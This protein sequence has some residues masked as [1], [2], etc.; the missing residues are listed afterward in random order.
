MLANSVTMNRVLFCL[1]GLI[2]LSC[3]VWLFSTF[4]ELDGHNISTD[5]FEKRNDNTAVA[6][7]LSDDKPSAAIAAKH[8]RHGFDQIEDDVN[9]I[10]PSSS[11]QCSMRCDSTL[12]MLD[13]NIELNDEEFRNLAA[14]TREIATYL[15]NNKDQR[16]YFMQM[17]LTTTDGD[18]RAYL[19][20]VFKHLPEEQKVKVAESFVDSDNWRVRA[21]G[22]TLI[23]DNGV[24]NLA[25]ASSLMD[26]FS[27]EESSYIKERILAYIQNSPTLRGDNEM[28]QQLDSAIY[29]ESNES[30]R[31][32]ALKAKMQ[33][34]EQPYDILPD[35]LQA[36]RA[37][38]PEL[39]LAGI[40]AIEQV[41]RHEKKYAESGAY[42]DT[43]SIKNEFQIIQN[44]A[45][46]GD[47]KKRMDRLIEEA[48]TVYLRYFEY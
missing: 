34:G 27:S 20:D 12:S 1:A 9:G 4:I 47:D 25:A 28:L 19:T 42:I 15:Q 36:L 26:I 3:L 38:E 7:S 13:Q 40:V 32:A 5:Q 10:D 37:S 45:S 30:V 21:D 8:P 46:Y 41:L 33:L 14:Y 24:E 39:Q 11:F 31:V 48:N 6:L 29:A 35:A 44:L 17:A 18:K 2:G 22:V 16:Q 23:A 43:S